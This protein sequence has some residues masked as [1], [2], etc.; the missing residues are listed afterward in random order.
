MKKNLLIVILLAA[1]AFGLGLLC[2]F[3]YSAPRQNR[4]CCLIRQ[5][6]WTFE[7]VNEKWEE[8]YPRRP[9]VVKMTSDTTFKSKYHSS[10]IVDLL[11]ERP[12]WWFFGQDTLSPKT[13]APSRALLCHSGRISYPAHRRTATPTKVLSPVVAGPVK[14]L[15]YPEWWIR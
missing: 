5:T 6:T 2:Q 15:M 7:S 1:F 8:F 10:N 11:E 9:P 12:K 3:D 4:K 14:A 13:M